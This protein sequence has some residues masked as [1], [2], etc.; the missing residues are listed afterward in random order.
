MFEH[1][2]PPSSI[3]FEIANMRAIILMK[4]DNDDIDWEISNE[5]SDD[6]GESTLSSVI[7]EDDLDIWQEVLHLDQARRDKTIQTTRD[8]LPKKWSCGDTVIACAPLPNRRHPDEAIAPPLLECEKS[9]INISCKSDIVHALP[10]PKASGDW[11]VPQPKA[12]G[13]HNVPQHQK[14][15]FGVAKTFMEAIVFRKTPWQIIS[16][17]K[18]SMIEDA[19]KLAI[20]TQDPQRAL[21]G[22]PVGTPSV[23]Q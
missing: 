7:K 16:D 8:L 5:K 17:D 6:P 11:N 21:A 12:G 23:C 22:A 4:Q 14:V 20:E 15:T 19:L 1:P 2:T 13:D 9:A 3:V 10:L 18:Y